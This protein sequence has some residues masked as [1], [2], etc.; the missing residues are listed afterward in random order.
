M[1]DHDALSEVAKGHK[2][3]MSSNIWLLYVFVALVVV[4]IAF[5]FIYYKWLREPI[6]RG[7]RKKEVF[8]RFGTV[9][10]LNDNEARYLK[11]ISNQYQ[12][13]HPYLIFVKRSIF[14]EASAK[15]FASGVEI[16]T[17]RDK[18]YRPE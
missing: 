9:N 16:G 17:L 2:E 3:S 6:R 14:E 10:E 5:L 1:Q 4:A 12:L 15:I 13:P 7:Q 18:L 11:Q 8:N